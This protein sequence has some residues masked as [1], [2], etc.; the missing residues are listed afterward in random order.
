[1]RAVYDDLM[2]TRK[3]NWINN[4]WVEIDERFQT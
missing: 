1:V 4:F 3:T 2:A